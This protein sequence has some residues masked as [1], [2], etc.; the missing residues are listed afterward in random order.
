[1]HFCNWYMWTM[2][3]LSFVANLLLLTTTNLPLLSGMRENYQYY[4]WKQTI[5]IWASNTYWYNVEHYR[6]YKQAWQ[7]ISSKIPKIKCINPYTLLY[8]FLWSWKV[9]MWG[10]PPVYWWM[11]NFREYYY[12]V[13]HASHLN[14]SIAYSRIFSRHKTFA[15]FISNDMLHEN[16]IMKH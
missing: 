6:L 13:T 2:A 11:G 15:N 4:W 8:S 1:M 10:P 16:M 3:T 5:I 14:P 12:D 7:E 9:S